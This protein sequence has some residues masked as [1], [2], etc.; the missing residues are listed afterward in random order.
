MESV[1]ELDTLKAQIQSLEEKLEQKKIKQR[2]AALKYDHKMKNSEEYKE[3]G[4]ER[5]RVRYEN[6]SHGGE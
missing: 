5:R 4:K 3:K 1:D 6:K 2:E